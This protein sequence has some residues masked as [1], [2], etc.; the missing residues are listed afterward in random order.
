MSAPTVR[1]L[2]ERYL[3]ER[4]RLGFDLRKSAYALRS[5]A[6]HVGAAGHRGPLTVEIMA[7]WAR[8]DSHGS[9][10]PRT[11]ARRLKLL[12]S[13]TRWLQQFEPR[14]EIPD[15]AIFGRLPER[16]A[17]HIY[18]EQEF[19]DLLAAARRL[20]PAPGLR[21]VVFETLFGLIGSCG[22]R[23]SEAVGLRN[24]DVDL[25]HG[26]LTL[27]RTKFGKSRQVPM[28]QSCI[29]AL[30]RYRSMRDLSGESAQDEAA[31]FVGTRGQR[32]GMPL[33]THGVER[34][35]AGLREQLGWRNRGAHHAPR[36]HDLRH[37]MVVRRVMLWHSQ[38]V[39]IDQAML[40]LSTYVGHVNVTN[41]YWYLSAVPELIALAAQRFESSMH[42]SEVSHA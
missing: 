6:C 34:V 26:M 18:S 19:V 5:F 29:E 2:V 14:T 9:T 1:T 33:S 3:V 39:D 30:R 4:R 27:R 12:R 24:M 32:R 22:L 42:P 16:Q 37:T 36:I 15:D 10:D 25:E 17:P 23:L 41:T 7:D 13:F 40:A 28:H 35:F 8:R 11:W 31:F 38:G 21:G 20:G